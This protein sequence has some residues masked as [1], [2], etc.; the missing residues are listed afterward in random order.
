[1]TLALPASTRST[2]LSMLTMVLPIAEILA[3]SWITLV[4]EAGLITKQEEGCSARAVD[5]SVLPSASL[6]SSASL[7]SLAL[8]AAL[9]SLAPVEPSARIVTGTPAARA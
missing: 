7:A 2:G 1:M 9:V 3:R 4:P 5:L 6:T 8:L